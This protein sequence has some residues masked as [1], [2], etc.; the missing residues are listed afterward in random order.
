MLYKAGYISC[1][2]LVHRVRKY[3]SFEYKTCHHKNGM[4]LDTIKWLLEIIR[5]AQGP[6]L[7]TGYESEHYGCTLFVRDDKLH[8]NIGAYILWSLLLWN[9]S[10]THARPQTPDTK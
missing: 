7:Q 9:A 4:P 6:E 10:I 2:Y 8:W 1:I 3:L 5:L